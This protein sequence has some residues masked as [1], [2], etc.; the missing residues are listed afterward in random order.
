[1]MIEGKDMYRERYTVEIRPHTHQVRLRTKEGSF[2]VTHW[3]DS[4]SLEKFIDALQTAYAEIAG[5]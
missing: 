3:H 5:L 1:M 2:A 4:H